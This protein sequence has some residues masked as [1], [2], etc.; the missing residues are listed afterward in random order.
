LALS[1]QA[2]QRGLEEGS[3]YAAVEDWDAHL[4]ALADHLLLL[5]VKLFGKLGRGE[6][7]GHG[8]TSLIAEI[9]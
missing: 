3:V 2:A 4:H 9:G 1:A 5:H 6:V 8:Q 7:I